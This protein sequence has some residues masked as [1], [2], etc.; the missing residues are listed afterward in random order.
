MPQMPNKISSILF[1]PEKCI[2]N[3]DTQKLPAKHPWHLAIRFTSV[4]EFADILVAKNEF[5][6]GLES[7]PLIEILIKL[8]RMVILDTLAE[9]LT[10]YKSCVIVNCNLT[11]AN[12]TSVADR[13]G[14]FVEALDHFQRIQY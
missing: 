1:K 11:I 13:H 12:N 6:P 5:L 9:F 8:S 14:I 7:L 10:V 2:I 3:T 4:E